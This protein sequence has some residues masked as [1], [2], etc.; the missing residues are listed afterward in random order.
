MHMSLIRIY[1]LKRKE[2][3]NHVYKNE[4]IDVTTVDKSLY[5][6]LCKLRDYE[7][8]GLNPGDFR[9]YSYR[10]QYMYKVVYED[11]TGR[12]RIMLCETDNEAKEMK[13][14]LEALG[15]RNV[16]WSMFDRQVLIEESD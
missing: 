12:L 13:L 11:K 6:P 9:A 15:Y 16:T 10:V 8:T 5:G 2:E 1:G 4:G 14:N 7:K 3:K